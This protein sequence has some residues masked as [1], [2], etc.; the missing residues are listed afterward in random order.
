MKGRRR[1]TP[2]PG[3]VIAS[4]ALLFALGGTSYATVAATLP[5]NSAAPFR[6]YVLCYKS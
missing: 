1:F 2:A 4:I 3:T 6:V 5:R